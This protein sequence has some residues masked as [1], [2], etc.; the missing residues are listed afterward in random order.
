M[1]FFFSICASE[2]S[3]VLCMC[4]KDHQLMSGP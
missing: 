4:D 3:V 2:Y 1:L